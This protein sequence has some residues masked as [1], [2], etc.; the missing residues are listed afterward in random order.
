MRRLNARAKI[1]ALLIAVLALAA[2]GGGSS[3]L[4]KPQYEQKIKT[5]G[6]ALQ[7]AFTSIDIN[8]NKNLKEL[9][10]KIGQL[11]TK[12]EQTA[13]DFDKLKPPKDAEADNRKI[14]Q[15]LH[16][17]AD[18]F[19]QL[20]KAANAG[21]RM[22]LAAGQSELISA[23]RAGAEATNDLKSKG[24]DVGALGGTG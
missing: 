5:E 15:T 4:S 13:N 9:G 20:Q 24:Y 21:D 23:S 12:L 16:R 11:R 17:F 8:T 7:S 18:I 14:A 6:K 3:R 2:C 1:V 19:G 10:T 22:K